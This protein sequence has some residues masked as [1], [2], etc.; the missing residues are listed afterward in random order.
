MSENNFKPVLTRE[1]LAERYDLDLEKDVY[2]LNTFEKIE[3]AV[4]IFL[5]YHL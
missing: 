2:L 4:Y 5:T 3:K 1:E